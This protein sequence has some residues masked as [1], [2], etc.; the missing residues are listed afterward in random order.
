[1]RAG[2]GGIG[3]SGRDPAL[4][5]HP[6]FW[7]IPVAIAVCASVHAQTRDPLPSWNDG[8]IKQGIVEFVRGTTDMRDRRFVPPAER[9]AVFDNDGTLWA[10]QPMYTQLAF[11][12]DRV[13]ALAP[14]HPEWR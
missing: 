8:S 14:S 3:R 4:P 13:K 9:I 12:L 7:F 2:M 6:A 5:A 10:E 11:A 1:M